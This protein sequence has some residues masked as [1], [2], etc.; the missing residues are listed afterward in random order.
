MIISHKY[1][2]IFIKNWK[3]ASTSIEGYLAKY[4]GQDD[5]IATVPSAIG[6]DEEKN[7]KGLFNPVPEILD[8]NRITVGRDFF[9]ITSMRR[10]LKDFVTFTKFYNH[11]PA[12]Q[13]QSRVPKRIWD[14]YYKFCFERSP[15]DKV[16]SNFFML[17]GAHV[18]KFMPDLTFEKYMEDKVFL[19][20]LNY[21]RYMDNKRQEKVIVDHIGKYEDLDR[22]MG[23][24]CQKLNIPYEA[25][26]GCI[27]T[28]APLKMRKRKNISA[29]LKINTA[30]CS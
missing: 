24:I 10:T 1:K 19:S 2:F 20:C 12:Y 16:I 18:R 23:K 17:K 15:W 13:V 8:C 26:L 28:K 30:S 22:E 21:P 14:T 27:Y 29:Y 6:I 9:G 5:V 7:V 25:R 4:C 3:T 11:M